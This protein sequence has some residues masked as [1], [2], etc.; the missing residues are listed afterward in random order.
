MHRCTSYFTNIHA[1][2][3]YRTSHTCIS[4]NY[5]LTFG[6]HDIKNSKVLMSWKYY[7]SIGDSPSTNIKFDQTSS[8]T[9]ITNWVQ[10]HITH[11]FS[12]NDENQNIAFCHTTWKYMYHRP[13]YLLSLKSTP[14]FIVSYYSKKQNNC[15]ILLIHVLENTSIQTSHHKHT[16]H[17]LTMHTMKMKCENFACTTR[18]FPPQQ[19]WVSYWYTK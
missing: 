11:T 2:D 19:N 5:C 15:K 9:C 6:M 14:N 18:T 13:R 3:F 8:L 16:Q 17:S 1:S 12:H 4:R 10:Q 7:A